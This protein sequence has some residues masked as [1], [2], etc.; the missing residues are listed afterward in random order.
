MLALFFTLLLRR[1]RTR[2]PFLS[3]LTLGQDHWLPDPVHDA[4][5]TYGDNHMNSIGRTLGASI[6]GIFDVLSTWRESAC[7]CVCECV[8]M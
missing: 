6:D 1:Q 8:C 3:S 4:R 7:V 5:R 2:M